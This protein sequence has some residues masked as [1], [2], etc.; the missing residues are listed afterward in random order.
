M[1]E[2]LHVN[3]GSVAFT[4]D[5][6]A[7]RTL[8]HYLDEIKSRL[9]E[10]TDEVMA[11]IESRIAEILREKIASPMRVVTLEMVEATMEQIGS[12]D[13]FG[14]SAGEAATAGEEE[15]APRK[16][17]RS[18]HNRSIAG[19]CGGIGEFFDCDPTLVRLVCFLLIFCGGM[20]IYIYLLAWIIIPEADLGTGYFNTNDKQ[21]K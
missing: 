18:L 17:R 19:V 21:K 2:T 10:D 3:I 15:E 6:D 1:K 14:R 9:E 8:K 7:Y 11:D 5:E 16:L 12:P 4:L 20:S 13:C